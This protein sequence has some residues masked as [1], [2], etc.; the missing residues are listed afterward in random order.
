M[1]FAFGFRHGGKVSSG[2]NRLWILSG[3]WEDDAALREQAVSAPGSELDDEPTVTTS[4]SA[5][6]RFCWAGGNLWV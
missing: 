2:L 4:A 1:D 3:R 5:R 6:L